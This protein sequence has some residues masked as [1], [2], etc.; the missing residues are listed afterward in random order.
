MLQH[1]GGGVNTEKK[2]MQHKSIVKRNGISSSVD[3]K[4]QFLNETWESMALRI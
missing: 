1:Y 3:G 2:K 4:Y